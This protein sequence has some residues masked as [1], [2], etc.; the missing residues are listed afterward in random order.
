VD[1][2]R[3]QSRLWFPAPSR[4]GLARIG[5]AGRALGG[6]ATQHGTRRRKHGYRAEATG[7]PGLPGRIGPRIARVG[8]RIQAVRYELASGN[9]L[10]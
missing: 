4:T 10:E 5:G 2:A 7:R 1:L 9:R 8:A 3:G 6:E